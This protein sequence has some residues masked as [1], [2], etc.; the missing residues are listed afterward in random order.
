MGFLF[1][2]IAL[3]ALVA[4]TPAVADVGIDLD[5]V[6]ALDQRHELVPCSKVSTDP[7][8]CKVNGRK[9]KGIELWGG[10][11]VPHLV[12]QNRKPTSRGKCRFDVYES[13]KRASVSVGSI[14]IGCALA[15]TFRAT[16]VEAL[17]NVSEGSLVFS[18]SIKSVS[19]TPDLKIPIKTSDV[20]KLSPNPLP[21]LGVLEVDFDVSKSAEKLEMSYLGNGS[22]EVLSSDF[23]ELD[24]SQTFKGRF[25]VIKKEGA[26]YLVQLPDAFSLPAGRVTDAD[27]DGGPAFTWIEVEGLK[28]AFHRGKLGPLKWYPELPTSPTLKISVTTIDISKAASPILHFKVSGDRVNFEVPAKEG[29][30]TRKRTP[31]R[32]AYVPIFNAKSGVNVWPGWSPGC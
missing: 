12:L 13:A 27:P 22:A 24:A 17:R 10:E 2:V 14:E 5:E 26:R 32:D 15:K 31:M 28:S 23:S 30:L 21:W 19:L 20:F 25:P 18:P 29:V 6:Q 7:D 9:L 16:A 3:S 8:A 4:T 11:G 1:L